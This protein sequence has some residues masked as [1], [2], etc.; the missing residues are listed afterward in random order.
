M[1]QDDDGAEIR[2]VKSELSGGRF[3]SRLRYK[4]PKA[5]KE[6]LPLYSR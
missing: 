3:E 4:S 5:D 6:T 2:P 1:R